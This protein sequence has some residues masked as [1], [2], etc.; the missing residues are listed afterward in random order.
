[1]GTKEKTLKI[2]PAYQSGKAQKKGAAPCYTFQT[3]NQKPK[4]R[5]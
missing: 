2:N 3:K 5:V 1:M 4:F